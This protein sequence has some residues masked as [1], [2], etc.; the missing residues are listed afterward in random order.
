MIY[1]PNTYVESNPGLAST[2]T[3]FPLTGYEMAFIGFGVC[4][5]LIAMLVL[6]LGRPR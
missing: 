2:F 5:L 6:L 3:L 4:L 1:P